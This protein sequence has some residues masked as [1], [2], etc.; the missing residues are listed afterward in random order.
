MAPCQ[1]RKRRTR[2]RQD[3]TDSSRQQDI[4]HNRSDHPWAAIPHHTPDTDSRRCTRQR[5]NRRNRYDRCLVAC[6]QHRPSRPRRPQTRSLPHP[7]SRMLCSL[8]PS[9]LSWVRYQGHSPDT[10]DRRVSTAQRRCRNPSAAG[11]AGRPH[12]IAH[13]AS[14]RRC[15]K[16]HLSETTS[17]AHMLSAERWV[18]SRHCTGRTDHQSETHA[19]CSRQSMIDNRFDSST[20]LCQQHS[21]CKQ[22]RSDCTDSFQATCTGRSRSG[23]PLAGSQQYMLDTDLRR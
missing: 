8:W 19:R 9:W 7:T 22:S 11:W 5:H 2:H 6:Q 3:Y 21:Q 16:M 14:R 20:A 23:P 18:D 17:T 15:T 10:A 13:K 12:H 1:P 4:D